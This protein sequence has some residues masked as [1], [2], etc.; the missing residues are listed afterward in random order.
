[1]II[2]DLLAEDLVINEAFQV[3]AMIEKLPPSWKDFKKYLKHK[4]KKMSL[5]DLIVRL[6]TEEDNKAADERS[7]GNSTILEANIV[8]D[9]KGKLC[10]SK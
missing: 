6:R 9:E 4:I 5:E 7:H 1:L 10:T 8:E 2:N 3:A